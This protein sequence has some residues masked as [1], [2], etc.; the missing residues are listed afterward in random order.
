MSQDPYLPFTSVPEWFEHQAR[1]TPDAVAVVVD[2][3]QEKKVTYAELNRRANQLARRLEK[4]GVGPD[5]VV[6]ICLTRSLD[7]IVGLLGVLKA[8]GAYLPIDRDLPPDRQALMLED[9]QPTVLLTQ[10][11]IH[12]DL[13]PSA[14][15][16]FLC[17][18]EGAS[19]AAE[20]DQDVPSRLTADNLAYVIYTSGSTGKPKGVEIPH[21][22]LVNFLASMKEQPGLTSKDVLVAITTVSFDIAGLE[23]FLPLVTGARLIFLN[24]DDV[25]DGFRIIHHLERHQ[26]TVLQATPST[27]R[28]LLD[29]KW[30]GNPELK[31]LCGG[32]GLPRDLANQLLAKGGELWNMYGPTETT[33][34]SAI[35]KVE[36]DPAPITIGQP[37][38]NT[39]LHIL[40]AR[41][42]PVPPGVPGELHIG[43]LGLARGYRFRPELTAEKFIPDPF[44]SLPGARLYK[45][46]D[47][48]RT[49]A[50][51]RIEVQG[52]MDHQ[53]KIRGYRIELGEIE[54]RLGKY[55]GIKE[56]VVTAHEVSPG[57]KQL[58]AYLVLLPELA[59]SAE[60]P[61]SAKLIT[62]LR[63][64][65]EQKLPDYMVP[66]FFEFL[67]AFPLTPNG[68]IDRKA[69]PAPKVEAVRAS[70]P[71]VAPQG[72]V[73][74]KLA[75]I[76][77]QI[78]G[79]DR[80]GTQDNIFEIGGDSLL[81]F[82]IAARANEASLPL[83]VRQFFQ[84]GT[85]AELAAEIARAT[86][87]GA[88]SRPALVPVDRTP[89]RSVAAST[90]EL[91][92]V[93]MPCS[94]SQK[95]HWMLEQIYPGN[96]ALEV[97]IAL[98]L[99]GPLHVEILERALNA[100]VN[101]HETL[102]TQFE[103][104]DN[105]PRQ[106]I[107]SKVALKLN[108]IQLGD[109]P[110][111]R[112]Q[113]RLEEEMAADVK[114]PLALGQAPL[115]RANLVEMSPTKNVLML[116]WHHIVSDGWSSAVLILELSR[117]YDAFARGT[118]VDLPPLKT[119]YADYVVWQEEWLKTTEAQKQLE[120]WND[121]LGGEIPVIDF[122]T[123][124]ARPAGQASQAAIESLL[125]PPALGEALKSFCLEA[126]VTPFMVFSSAYLVL[127]HRYTG[128]TKLMVGTTAANRPEPELENLI[129]MFANILML[130][131][132][133]SP[134]MSFRELLLRQ[135][136]RSLSSFAN[137]E[138]PFELVLEHLQERKCRVP[139]TL[140]QT[141][142][143]YQKAFLQPAVAGGVSIDPLASPSPGSMFELLFRGVERT[144]G[145]RLEMEYRTSLFK[146]STIHRMLLHFQAL[147]ESVTADPQTPIEKLSLFTGHE[148]QELEASLRLKAP[149]SAFDPGVVLEDFD[150]QL[151]EHFQKETSPFLPAQLPPGAALI[152]LDGDLRLLPVGIPGD[153]YL[154]HPG[155]DS[156]G[157]SGPSD[158]PAPVPL[159]KTGFLGR[160]A[161]QGA[162]ELWGRAEDVIPLPVFRGNRRT[163]EV[164]L[165]LH[166]EVAEAAVIVQPNAAQIVGYVALKPGATV[167]AEGL[168]AFLKGQ[169]SEP[170]AIVV[171]DALPRDA[172]GKVLTARLP[173]PVS[174][175]ESEPNHVPLQGILHQQLL[176]IWRDI[177]KTPEIGIN[178]NFFEFGGN[179]FLALRMMLQAEKLCRR[180][181]PL[182][183]LL[184]GAT[185]ANLAHFIIQ[186]NTESDATMP[187]V[188][189]QTKGT[190]P[191]LFF[192]HGDWVGGGF[193]CNRLSR[194]LGEEQPF[195]ALPPYRMREGETFDIQEMAAQ[196]RAAMEK[197][198]P[199]GPYLVGGYCIGALIAIEVAQQLVAEGKTVGHL[200]LIDPPVWGERWL[201]WA[202]RS[203]DRLGNARGWNPQQKIAFFDRYAVTLNRRLHQPLTASRLAP[204]LRPFGLAARSQAFA[205]AGAPEMDSSGEE[206][207]EG[208]DYALYYL[209]Y[210]LYELR[211][212]SVPA[213]FF[214]PESAAPPH[215]SRLS[216]VSQ[217][218]PAKYTIEMVP[219]NH[220]TCVTKDTSV[221]VGKMRAILDAQ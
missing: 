9:A 66:S 121:A 67:A 169:I 52:R 138:A 155:L 212:L 22:A 108:R 43:G 141:H 11:S 36:P 29:A 37:I 47:L 184:T 190:R 104:F 98:E 34:W 199:G 126:G 80:V 84:H 65:L 149:P 59:A 93:V 142:F 158:S 4:L 144:E 160:N 38:A 146:P 178:D 125:L 42:Q 5:Q 25:V 181:L 156:K 139:K 23:I 62:N 119:H 35:A 91:E 15:P 8:G 165:R 7:L 14:V 124:W 20:N 196:H 179:S 129:G 188:P 45:T 57:R 3:G 110:A 70:R 191:P 193:Y 166:P 148:R 189:V 195:Y 85:I 28:M 162:A 69:L 6:A 170:T 103:L 77:A 82:R 74:T 16:V 40:D 100:I 13:P 164:R 186:T 216:R 71:Y 204:L 201:R 134:G 30:Q 159:L 81:I 94:T 145:I 60:A 197:Q 17:D 88:S 102:R 220:T 161:E 117:F 21:R 95:R 198:C 131:S 90:D 202:W 153:L 174:S 180:P 79:R 115:L 99:R 217:M 175:R 209:A 39:Q 147:L 213:T 122:P 101:R 214:F 27:W 51:G 92:V 61:A 2:E 143:L 168:R 210:R 152:A 76:W 97:P 46:G 137:Y 218:D 89:Y 150:R 44:S 208:L 10:Q 127:L 111:D 173:L 63:E 105:E 116:T 215:L 86:S 177:L 109:L 49:R 154:A 24:R 123:D 96:T 31:M 151:E 41:L 55:P 54:A 26:A 163:V 33:I 48:A 78:L 157:V 120:Y 72:P 1:A 130:R 114:L 140:V 221:L 211:P 19:L 87:S 187:L 203:V 183:L 206:M 83:T 53:V 136:D 112:Q 205:M 176:E 56:A 200:F 50:G 12:A 18:A 192:L 58:V 133:V 128:Q 118:P 107:A 172:E 73:E 194:Q 171:L 68:K 64:F 113:E 182:S 167:T 207:L 75:E 106:V 32:E 135:R 219:G 185:I 132:D